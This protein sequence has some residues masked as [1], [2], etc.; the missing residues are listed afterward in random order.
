MEVLRMVILRE[1]LWPMYT[2]PNSSTGVESSILLGHTV[3][4]M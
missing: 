3:E 2:R 4:V 1:D